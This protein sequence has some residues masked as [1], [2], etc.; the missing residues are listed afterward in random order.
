MDLIRVIYS[1][2]PFGFDQAVLN[3]ILV[4]GPAQQCAAGSP[5]P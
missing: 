4:H 3:G 2:R 5:G 1:S